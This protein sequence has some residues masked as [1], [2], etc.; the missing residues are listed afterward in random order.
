MTEVTEYR[1]GDYIWAKG[2][3]FWGQP[4]PYVRN[5]AGK[6]F[7]VYSG[8]WTRARVGLLALWMIQAAHSLQRIMGSD[9]DQRTR[10]TGKEAIA[11]FA[12]KGEQPQINKMMTWSPGPLEVLKIDEH[13]L[14]YGRTREW[15]RATLREARSRLPGLV[16]DL[17]GDDDLAWTPEQMAAGALR[18]PKLLMTLVRQG[19]IPDPGTLVPEKELVPG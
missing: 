14:E 17:P 6:K 5:D 10:A 12:A 19:E 13:V 15:I 4:L 9:K 18:L 11:H 2:S 7:T 1:D 8:W 16:E 3:K